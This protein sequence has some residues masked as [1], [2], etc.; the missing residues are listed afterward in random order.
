MRTEKRQQVGR[1][2]RIEI[3]GGNIIACRIANLS[4]G[5]ALLLVSES[6]WLPPVFDLVDVFSDTRRTVRVAWAFS[7]RAGIRFLSGRKAPTRKSGSFG[8]RG[9]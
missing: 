6:E 4:P 2:A 3:E 5:G 8:K 9:V 7:G 1:P